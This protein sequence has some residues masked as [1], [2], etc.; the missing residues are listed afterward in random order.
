[1]VDNESKVLSFYKSI[2]QHS[3][4]FCGSTMHFYILQ[5]FLTHPYMV[6]QT[7]IITELEETGNEAYQVL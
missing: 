1:M 3:E 2:R 5:S 7:D 6:L 4:Y